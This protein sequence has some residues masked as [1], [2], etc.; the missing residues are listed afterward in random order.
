MFKIFNELS[1]PKQYKLVG[2]ATTCIGL[3]GLTTVFA[4]NAAMLLPP[5][6]AIFIAGLGFSHAARMTEKYDTDKKAKPGQKIL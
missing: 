4:L 1:R 6:A 5:A 2:Q 3:A